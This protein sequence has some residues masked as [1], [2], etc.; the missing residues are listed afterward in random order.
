MRLFLWAIQNSPDGTMWQGE[1]RRV[2]SD[3]FQLQG[4]RSQ[5]EADVAQVLAEWFILRTIS[6]ESMTVH[7]KSSRYHFGLRCHGA[8]RCQLNLFL[9]RR[10]TSKSRRARRGKDGALRHHRNKATSRRFTA[11]G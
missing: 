10:D 5:V 6:R 3:R 7:E 8:F 1:V 4:A 9:E 2:F 11:D